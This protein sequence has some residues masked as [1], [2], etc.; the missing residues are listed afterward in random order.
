MPKHNVEANKQRY[1]GDQFLSEQYEYIERIFYGLLNLMP[2]VIR[3]FTYKIIFCE[4]GF[5]N[6]IGEN[7]IFRYPW[8]IKLGNRIEIGYGARIYPSFKV[9]DAYIHI[10]DGVTIAPGLTIFGAGHPRGKKRSSHV[11]S[12]VLIE[13][14]AYIGGNVTIRY[15]V[16][17]GKGAVVAAGSVVVSDVP[18]NITVGGVPARQITS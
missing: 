1:F 7:C 15:G 14:D 11:A 12:S 8:K 16:T 9:K 17:I 5:K 3:K 6:K 18:P 10:R 4:F 13:E 2:P